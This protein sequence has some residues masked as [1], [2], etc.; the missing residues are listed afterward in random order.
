[1]VVAEAAAVAVVAEAAVAVAVA[2]AVLP[3]ALAASAE[4]VSFLLT[5]TNAN[6]HWPG[7]T[8]STR[9]IHVLLVVRGTSCTVTGPRIMAE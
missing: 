2:V 7:S 5:V 4:T 9:P 6:H 3:G 1:M 8:M